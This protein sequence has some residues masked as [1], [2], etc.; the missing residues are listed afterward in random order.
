MRHPSPRRRS[1]ENRKTSDS[2]LAGRELQKDPSY[3]PSEIYPGFL[4]LLLE[5]QDTASVTA[6]FYCL[7][8]L[9]IAQEDR[10]EDRAAVLGAPR[11]H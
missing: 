3:C 11:L 1:Q 2:A 4:R 9:G 10:T 7:F 6:A 5:W 8:P